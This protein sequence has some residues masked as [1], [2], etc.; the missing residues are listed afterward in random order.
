MKRFFLGL[1]AAAAL[2]F[3]GLST[4]SASTINVNP[5]P[6]DSFDVSVFYG[7]A[8]V[9]DKVY[10]FTVSQ[11]S[12]MTFTETL[13][14]NLNYLLSIVDET[15]N[16]L[17]SSFDNLA[18]GVLYGLHVTTFSGP[19]FSGLQGTANFTAAVTPIPPALLLFA[20]SLVGLGVVGYRRRNGTAA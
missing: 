15:N 17:L 12:N 20:T 16:V 5:S 11:T 10:E 4:A 9:N 2:A 1:V 14:G 18:S 8:G 6:T 7:A 3:G 13:K 19:G